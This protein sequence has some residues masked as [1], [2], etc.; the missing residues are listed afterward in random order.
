MFCLC[1][2]KPELI[3]V[4]TKTPNVSSELWTRLLAYYMLR[5]NGVLHSYSFLFKSV[6]LFAWERTIYLAPYLKDQPKNP[7]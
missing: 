2:P 5:K 4:N 3:Y 6:E 1:M 7:S